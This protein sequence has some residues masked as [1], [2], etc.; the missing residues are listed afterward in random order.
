MKKRP[1]NP[2]SRPG[3]RRDLEPPPAIGF[4]TLTAHAVFVGGFPIV[5]GQLSTLL[6]GLQGVNLDPLVDDPEITVRRAAVIEVFEAVA[7]GALQRPLVGQLDEVDSLCVFDLPARLRQP[8][9]PTRN[10]SKLAPARQVDRGEHTAPLDWAEAN[11][12][13][14][15]FQIGNI[16]WHGCGAAPSLA[17]SSRNRQPTSNS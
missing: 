1:A 17:D 9:Q 10:F 5:H 15:G 7:F 11:A 12:R 4:A 3:L 16:L 14:S 2:V 6:D 8:D 13:C